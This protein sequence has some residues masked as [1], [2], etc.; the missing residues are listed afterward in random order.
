MFLERHVVETRVWSWR[1]DV[2]IACRCSYRCSLNSEE[3]GAYF[4][5]MYCT[6]LGT[7]LC[8]FSLKK[9]RWS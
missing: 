5:S 6:S 1:D 2:G 4:V 3:L 7:V 9:I 8:L